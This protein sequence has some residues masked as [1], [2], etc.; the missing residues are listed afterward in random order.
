M[1]LKVGQR[2]RSAGSPVEVIVIRAGAG[3][4]VK[5]NGCC[6]ATPG[7]YGNGFNASAWT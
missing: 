2:W 6:A 3:V 1:Q 5:A 7:A 4:A